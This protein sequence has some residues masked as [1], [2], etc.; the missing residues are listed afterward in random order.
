MRRWEELR[1]ELEAR[2]IELVTLCSD[3]TEEIRQGR[4]K[5]GARAVMLSDADLSV[6]RLYNLVNDK[7]NLTPK[8]RG[9]MPIPT[10]ILVDADCRVRWIDQAKDYQVRTSATRVRAA[11][12]QELGSG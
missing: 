1:P 8:G 10:T 2:G 11:I 6:T 12:E 9:P 4:A 3:S 7:H 5:H